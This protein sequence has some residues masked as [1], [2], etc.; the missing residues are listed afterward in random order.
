M[1]ADTSG[2]LQLAS[3]NGTVALTVSTGQLFGFG[4]T[5]PQRKV[6]I[7]GPDGASGLTEGNSRTVL[8]LD[9]NGAT[10]VNLAAGSANQSAI[11]FSSPSTSN[12]GAVAYDN[13]SNYLRFDTNGSERLRL[14]TSGNIL[15]GVTS[16]GSANPGMYIQNNQATST[17]YN[18][19]NTNTGGQAIFF[20]GSAF[21]G[22]T[23]CSFGWN[24]SAVASGSYVYSNPNVTF[25]SGGGNNN[26]QIGTSG[27]GSVKFYNGASQN[28]SLVGVSS[29]SQVCIGTTSSYGSMAPTRGSITLQGVNSVSD[30]AM[31]GVVINAY[32]TAAG[33]PYYGGN[34]ASNN[35]WGIGSH[36]GSSDNII[37][38][39]QIA[40]AAGGLIWSGS[41]CNIYA[42]AY[43]NASDYRIKENVV[44]YG[45]GALEK[46][47]ALRPVTYNIIAP[48]AQEGK[49]PQIN[50][51]EIGFIAHEI[52]EHVPE[53]VIGEKDALNEDGTENHQAVDYAKFTA[54]LVKAIQELN[55]KVTA[56]E[57][58]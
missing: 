35:A 39:A 38:I 7:V 48:E 28:F 31:G 34:W 8:F 17:G 47:L 15:N 55:A 32:S 33:L 18:I 6:T 21:S 36:S 23:Y 43:T 49:Q 14:D 51:T 3:N 42:G 53:V 54:V 57:N 58:K 29:Q 52:Q 40:Y 13:S 46:V 12:L 22:G 19:I 4:T 16:I 27:S 24:G 41:Y 37:R 10:Y 50:R 44:T 5:T 20:A 56:L 30:T 9:N 25:L 26:L 45:G 11:F 2:V 1:S